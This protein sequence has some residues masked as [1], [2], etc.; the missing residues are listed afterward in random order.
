M[1]YLPFCISNNTA[2]DVV[3][4]AQEQASFNQA[5][6][7][8][9]LTSRMFTLPRLDAP[10]RVQIFARPLGALPEKA[11]FG[12]KLTTDLAKPG[13]LGE[14][15]LSSPER[16]L[17]VSLEMQKSMK[18]IVIEEVKKKKFSLL[19]KP[20]AHTRLQYLSQS[21]KNLL[22][23]CVEVSDKVEAKAKEVETFI[24]EQERSGSGLPPSARATFV[25]VL[26][27][28]DMDLCCG[29]VMRCRVFFGTDGKE[30][31]TAV[32]RGHLNYYNAWEVFNEPEE[33]TLRLE[34]RDLQKAVEGHALLRLGDYA[35]KE[36]LYDMVVPA[37]DNDQKLVG[38]A[39]VR[40]VNAVDPAI[41]QAVF[42]KLEWMRE[43]ELLE[44]AL[45]R[46]HT[47]AYLEKTLN[48][49]VTD[50]SL[51]IAR[52]THTGVYKQVASSSVRSSF[53]PRATPSTRSLFSTRSLSLEQLSSLDGD[54]GTE[55]LEKSMSYCV[56]LHRLMK[57]PL[58]AQEL[59]GVYATATI[60]STTLRVPVATTVVPDEEVY[61]KA[62]ELTLECP[63]ASLGCEFV[64]EGR[65][66]VVASVTKGGEADK[67]GVRVGHI[68]ASVDGGDIPPT[69][70]ELAMLLGSE[71]VATLGFVAPPINTLNAVLFE[72]QFIFPA[73]C[74]VN[75]TAMKLSVWQESA[76]GDDTLL[77]AADLP[78]NR[79]NDQMRDVRLSRAFSACVGTA[80][81][82]F[83]VENELVETALSLN[84]KGFAVSVVNAEPRELVYVSVNDLLVDVDL[85]ESGKKTAELRVGSFQVDNQILGCR[86]PVLFGSPQCMATPNQPTNPTGSQNANPTGS[87]NANPTGSQNAN[88]TGSQSTQRSWLH[89][90]AIVLPHPSVLYVEYFSLLVQEMKI[91]ADSNILSQL[92][93]FVNDL[94]LDEVMLTE[95]AP[96]DVLNASPEFI[97]PLLIP[98]ETLNSTSLFA[99]QLE[100]QPLLITLTNKMD[101]AHPLTS[102]ILPSIPLLIPLQ[103][104]IDSAGT[105]LGNV[106]HSQIKLNSFVTDSLFITQQDLIARLKMHYVKQFL[107]QL[108]KII[109]SFSFLGNPFGLAENLT[110][111]VKAF[112]YEPMQGLVKSPKEFVGGLGRGTKSL[113][114]NTAY[115]VLNTVGKITGTVADGLSALSMSEEY[116]SDR[117]A[118]KGGLIYGVKEGVTGVV[119]D[120][121]KG[122]K[123]GFFGALGG[124]TK[125]VVGLVVKPV[126][127]VVDEATK[128]ID[129]VKNATQIEKRLERKRAPRYIYKDKCLTPFNA[130]L[131]GGQLLLADSK[132]HAEIPTDEEY[133]AHAVLDDGTCLV[134][135]STRF[136]WIDP[137]SKNVNR[138]LKY[139]HVVRMQAVQRSVRFETDD[140]TT[141]MVVLNEAIAAVL[142]RLQAA[143]VALDWAAVTNLV[144]RLLQGAGQ[145]VSPEDAILAAL[146]MGDAKTD[147]KAEVDVKTLEVVRAEVVRYHEGV[148]STNGMVF[149]AGSNVFT[150]Y[151]VEVESATGVKW[152]V[153]RRYTHFK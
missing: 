151:E 57:V 13:V 137:A 48:K 104:V 69:E 27:A 42:E 83:D 134:V 145:S 33:L 112:F 79:D 21:R 92:L 54:E 116:K 36:M 74:T 77:C 53:N 133:V 147:A 64:K 62:D 73:G 132:T 68:V 4:L 17:R 86:F 11:H 71:E 113:L 107:G 136:L 20:D 25:Q 37:Y 35:E 6:S 89:C 39:R 95:R 41:A 63:V 96:L 40:F 10:Q 124:V 119:K 45:Q 5:V 150:E 148:E 14:F 142:P 141:P 8:Q 115:G 153:Y 1:N 91:S 139:K 109:G 67:A 88:P 52:A 98:D 129:S 12:V 28:Y 72:Q 24:E 130:Y 55:D 143:V 118:G 9:P 110:S 122:A 2:M 26:S 85:F 138:M 135:G 38:Y 140:R 131:S 65:T 66:F 101:P 46:V 93:A 59:K 111:G 81:E 7:V 50:V 125:G 61:A 23:R 94:P 15:A 70:E 97:K 60:G 22:A 117:A 47:E 128:H 114:M 19:R 100:L 16:T 51:Q 105:L 84:L 44:A 32:V 76:K 49:K 43:K 75:E 30:N 56:T 87:Q 34:S 31:K 82:S 103:A 120:T 127:G 106:D 144:V 18:M 102:S 149:G 126:V 78:I 58:P 152:L 99:E 146:E 90:A 29:R 123:K 80:W 121:V 108:Y 3:T